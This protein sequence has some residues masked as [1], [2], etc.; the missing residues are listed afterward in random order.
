MFICTERYP[1]QGRPTPS[2]AGKQISQ[3]PSS[4]RETLR[5]DY[6]EIPNHCNSGFRISMSH[7]IDNQLT[8]VGPQWRTN[9]VRIRRKLAA[10]ATAS[11][12]ML[13]RVM[14]ATL[15]RWHPVLWE[16]EIRHVLEYVSWRDAKF[17]QATVE[18]ASCR[19]ISGRL[20]LLC[21]AHCCPCSYFGIYSRTYLANWLF[22]ASVV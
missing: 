9:T 6:G 22:C 14:A 12:A 19:R 15:V 7:N 16:T 4:P 2:S 5:R 18:I 21:I 20:F 17:S 11:S 13:S 1:R 3:T 10:A 8:K